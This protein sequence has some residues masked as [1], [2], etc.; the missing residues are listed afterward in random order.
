MA[1]HGVSAVAPRIEVKPND[2]GG[3]NL[4]TAALQTTRAGLVIISDIPRMN[5]TINKINDH[6]QW[7]CV[8]FHEPPY[9][10]VRLT[11]Q[12]ETSGDRPDGAG[13]PPGQRAVRQPRWR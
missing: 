4:G 11:E 9:Q 5:R 2:I 1:R 7:K 8:L 10:A 3:A 6:F 12:V 13:K